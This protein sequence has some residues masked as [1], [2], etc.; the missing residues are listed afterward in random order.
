MCGRFTL[1]TPLTVLAKQFQFELDSALGDVRPRY[2]IAPT[3]T[4]LAVRQPE[5]GAKRELVQLRWGGRAGNKERR[6]DVGDRDPDSID[7][8][9]VVD[10]VGGG[11]GNAAAAAI[12]IDS[13]R[14][15]KRDHTGFRRLTPRGSQRPQPVDLWI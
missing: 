2:D 6:T 13:L 12:R 8:C 9:G 10:A 11:C 14:V 5:Q 3:Q 7:R 15:Q 4:V 1:R